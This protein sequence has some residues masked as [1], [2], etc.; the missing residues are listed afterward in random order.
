LA[1]CRWDAALPL[2]SAEIADPV[3]PVPPFHFG[4]AVTRCLLAQTLT[5]T[6]V[7]SPSNLLAYFFLSDSGRCG[8]LSLFY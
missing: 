2:A 4:L 8:A 3:C 6:M 7:M 5:L 1:L